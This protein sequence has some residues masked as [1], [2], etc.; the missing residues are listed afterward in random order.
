MTKYAIEVRNFNSQGKAM[1][2]YHLV[3]KADNMEDAARKAN[4]GV[5]G[6]S[7]RVYVYEL[8]TEEPKEYWVEKKTVV[9]KEIVRRDS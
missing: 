5:D 1:S 2:D 6:R 4:L 8:A 9:T 7:A 3:V